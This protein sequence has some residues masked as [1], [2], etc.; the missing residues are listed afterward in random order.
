MGTEAGRHGQARLGAVTRKLD[1][2]READYDSRSIW[3][4]KCRN[5]TL[6]RRYIEYHIRGPVLGPRVAGRR[7][8]A[9]P[10]C[11]DGRGAPV[12]WEGRQQSSEGHGSADCPRGAKVWCWRDDYQS[13]TI[14]NR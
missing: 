2:A 13:A 11:R 6:S 4:P 8:E 9:A 3:N 12:S 7:P 5:D 10:A 1:R 14:R